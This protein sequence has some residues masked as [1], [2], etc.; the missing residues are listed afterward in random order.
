MT[1]VDHRRQLLLLQLLVGRVMMMVMVVRRMMMR[2]T[3]AM[4]VML[5]LCQAQVCRCVQH[6]Q[7]VRIL[8]VAKTTASS[9][10]SS[11]TTTTTAHT[12][13]ITEHPVRI[14]T[15]G[16]KFRVLRPMTTVMVMVMMMVMV[17]LFI[18]ILLVRAVDG[19]ET[20]AVGRTFVQRS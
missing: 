4:L 15:G 6:R 16:T 13:T 18:R 8:P 5:L 9:S 7:R 10:S 14:A 20:P 2:R 12:N 17:V 3:A 19:V 1:P 11:A